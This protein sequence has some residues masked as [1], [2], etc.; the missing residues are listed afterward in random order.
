MKSPLNLSVAARPVS[1]IYI[2][3]LFLA[4][5][6]TAPAFG[7]SDT[8]ET[9]QAGTDVGHKAHQH[10]SS[11]HDKKSQIKPKAIDMSE[12]RLL[13]GTHEEEG[14]HLTQE[15]LT[16]ANIRV[17]TLEAKPLTRNILAAGEVKVN[18]YT[19]Y[20]VSPRTDSVIVRRHATLG[21]HV[22]QGQA[23]VTL[24]SESMAKAQANFQI[25]FSEW[26]RI[27]NLGNESVSESRYA[28]IK[29]NYN[30][31]LGQLTALGLTSAAIAKLT[32]PSSG[33]LGEYTLV[34]QRSGAVLSDD[35]AQGQ[36]V[37]AGEKIMELADEKRLWVEARISPNLR[38]NLPIGTRA[39]VRFSGRSYEAKVIQ[40]AHTI[41]AETRTRI[42]RL[43]VDNV[44]DNLHSGMFVDVM[45][46]L[47]ASSPVVAVPE[48]ALLRSADGDWSVFVES[49]PG[50]FKAEE[51]ELGRLYGDYR[52]IFGLIPGTRVVTRGAFFIASE[53]AKGGFDPHGH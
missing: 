25:T 34:A 47:A 21:E 19:S 15:A 52:E 40:A 12:A 33:T 46:L 5:I 3:A 37:D 11:S 53:I 16:L 6:S 2:Y 43:A 28:T 39:E 30:S 38:L 18:G 8:H 51:V 9:L 36:R 22:E 23:L 24:F 31:A 48:T 42:V 44:D 32:A 45:F 35:F 20:I 50:E 27:K 4:A 41:D 49:H 10:D 29:S 1:N 7:R 14:L 17:N 13:E 26:Q